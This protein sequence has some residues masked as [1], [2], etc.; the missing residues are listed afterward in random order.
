MVLRRSQ[1]RKLLAANERLMTLTSFPRLG[2]PRFLYPHVEP[3]GEASH[4]LFIPDEAI[5]T[6]P[7]FRCDLRL[8]AR[9]A[10]P[11]LLTAGGVD[12]PGSDTVGPPGPSRPISGSD[13]APRSRSTSPSSRTRTRRSRSWKRSPPRARSPKGRRAPSRTTS[14]WTRCA[15]AWAAAA[16]RCAQRPRPVAWARRDVARR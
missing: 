6:H 16:C 7:R 15:S 4:S 3:R 11:T 8:C 10:R 2:C 5:N 13:E 12:A 9:L 14:T 1:V